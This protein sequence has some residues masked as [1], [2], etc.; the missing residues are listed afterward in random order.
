MIVG[1][2]G[3]PDSL[4]LLHLLKTVSAWFPLTLTVAH[5]NHQLR[6]DAAKDAEFVQDIAAQWNLSFASESHNIAEPGAATRR[7]LFE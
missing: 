2:S 4:C 1:V 5:L 7:I 6:D 3:G